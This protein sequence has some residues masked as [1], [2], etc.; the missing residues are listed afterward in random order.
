M[1]QGRNV[2]ALIVVCE[3]KHINDIVIVLKTEVTTFVNQIAE[4][5]HTQS[6]KYG[7][8]LGSQNKLGQYLLVW[9]LD[10]EVNEMAKSL[11]ADNA[12]LLVNTK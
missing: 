8:A 4:I 7:G 5:I 3:I 2:K 10:Q 1:K 11:G 12:N 6:S 9:K